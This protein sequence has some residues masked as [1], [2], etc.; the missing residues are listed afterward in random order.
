M[1]VHRV[2]INKDHFVDPCTCIH[3]QQMEST[4]SQLEYNVKTREGT[5][6]LD[7]QDFLKRRN[8]EAMKGT[9][10]SVT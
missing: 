6:R 10:F 8:V 4:W 3:T 7:L 5:C 2:V 9:K 1:S